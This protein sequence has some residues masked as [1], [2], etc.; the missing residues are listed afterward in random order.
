MLK[1]IRSENLIKNVIKFE[2]GLNTLTGPDDGTN[3][4]GKSSVL[5]LIDF[6]FGSDS[7][8]EHCNDVIEAVGE[9][10]IEMDFEFNGVIHSFCRKTN[11]SGKVFFISEN[12]E[13]SI[14]EY[15]SHLAKNYDFPESSNSFRST[16]TC[17]SRIWG[18]DNYNP[19]LPLNAI[20]K[21]KYHAVRT[22]ILKLFSLYEQVKE[23]EKEKNRL[24]SKNKTI[25]GVFNDGYVIKNN[26]KELKNNKKRIIEI[27]IEIDELKKTIENF[28][29]NAE[30]IV[31]EN[32]LNLKK[33]KD[34]LIKE[35]YITKN[36]LLIVD[37]N[38]KFGTKVNKRNFE[39]LK[40]FFS[41]INED[42]IA[43]IE[44]FHSGITK[45]MH[46]EL[47]N[48]KKNLEV[49]IS[50]IEK[51]IN[52]INDVINESVSI[53]EKPDGLIDKLLTLSIE[54]KKLTEEVKF[55]EIKSGIEKLIKSVSLKITDSISVSLEDIDSSVNDKV[56]EYINIYYDQDSIAPKLNL[57]ESKYEFLHGKDSGTGKSYSNMIALDMS[58]LYLTYLPILIHDL[59][60]FS[61]I[62]DHALEKI[63]KTYNESEKQIFI[64]IDKIQRF[65]P[66]TVG[67]IFDKSF[68]DL[69]KD[70]LAFKESWK[71]KN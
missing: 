47:K 21:E 64:A 38:L 33:Q 8:L 13:I 7:F 17:F 10:T 12:K 20:P 34:I 35:L 28:S 9:I 27:D 41:D 69:N 26:K 60:I 53:L 68:L 59:I 39:R 30:I 4:I 55:S 42:R 31:N 57:L 37:G 62:E 29:L 45:I 48:E 2:S 51:N 43:K 56:E 32:N 3:S 61:N 46:K 22:R 19:N 49:Y 52:E 54:E 14:D 50:E 1:E 66:E 36:K 24:T 44:S 25:T 6:V 71:N 11:E 15:R 63:F 18:K 67:L 40:D 70:R 16:V 58:F 23:L 5:M 65:S